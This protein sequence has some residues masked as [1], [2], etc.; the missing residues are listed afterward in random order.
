MRAFRALLYLRI[1]DVLDSDSV[2]SVS[3]AGSLDE[4]CEVA[5]ELALLGNLRGL[6]VESGVEV[7]LLSLALGFPLR[8]TPLGG[9]EAAMGAVLTNSSSWAEFSKRTSLLPS[10]AGFDMAAGGK[11]QNSSA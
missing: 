5:V 11:V 10:S 9:G 8:F 4:E 1:G 3:K 7:L 2:D 6:V